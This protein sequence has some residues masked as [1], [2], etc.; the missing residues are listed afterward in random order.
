MLLFNEKRKVIKLSN[1]SLN[2]SQLSVEIAKTSD[3]ITNLRQVIDS[4]PKMV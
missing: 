1:K 2:I 4:R 3:I